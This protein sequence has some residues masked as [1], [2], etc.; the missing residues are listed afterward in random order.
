MFS[1]FPVKCTGTIVNKVGSLCTSSKWSFECRWSD[2]GDSDSCST[3]TT[4]GMASACPQKQRE[5]ADLNPSRTTGGPFVTNR[6]ISLISHIF[7]E[8]VIRL[9]NHPSR[10][11]VSDL[12]QKTKSHT[13]L[14]LLLGLDLIHKTDSRTD[15][16]VACPELE[17][18]ELF[19]TI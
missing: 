13:Y 6:F 9:K 1:G 14:S 18:G 10:G 8:V 11:M 5:F 2:L 19:V 15:P 17:F 16:C 4:R 3:L 7:R 12:E